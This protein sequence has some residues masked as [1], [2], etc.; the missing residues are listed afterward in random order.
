MS[1]SKIEFRLGAIHFIGEGDREWVTKQL[2]KIIQ[3]APSLLRVAGG[4]EEAISSEWSQPETK[5]QNR[6]FQGTKTVTSKTKTSN[7]ASG[8]ASMKITGSANDLVSYIKSRN[9]DANQRMKFL[10]TAGWLLSK[11]KKS[12]VT[13]DV[14]KA[15]KAAKLPQLINP[16]QY[17]GQN[18]KQGYFKKAGKEF[19]LSQKGTAAL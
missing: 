19:V 6:S 2:D 17:L 1:Q 13:R 12:F 9:A 10:A 16:S 11:G 15:I 4:S 18:L 5:G 8:M 14:T 3:Q 7:D